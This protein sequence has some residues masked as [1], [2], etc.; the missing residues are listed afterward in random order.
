[1]HIHKHQQVACSEQAFSKEATNSLVKNQSTNA[2][3]VMATTDTSETLQDF[4]L[5]RQMYLYVYYIILYYIIFVRIH[6]QH[7]HRK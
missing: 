2:Q 5:L 6:N 1:M 3:K 4:K 7:L